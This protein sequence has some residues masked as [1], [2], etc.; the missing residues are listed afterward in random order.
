MNQAGFDG[1]SALEEVEALSMPPPK[2]SCGCERLRGR[3]VSGGPPA[4]LATDAPGTGATLDALP[5]LTAVVGIDIDEIT[6][7]VGPHRP[8]PS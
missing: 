8:A 2:K 4:R 6:A 7:T 1:C 3:A 5:C